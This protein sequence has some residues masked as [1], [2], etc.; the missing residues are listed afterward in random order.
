MP[1]LAVFYSSEMSAEISSFS[2]SASKPQH[3]I[4]NWLEQKQPIELT[5][6]NPVTIEQIC[7]AHDAAYVRDILA[8]RTN[9]GFHNRSA[10]VA[11]SLPYTSGSLLSAARHAI[12]HNSVAV[13]PSSGFH[14]A[15]HGFAEGYCTFNGLVIT[16]MAL[17]Q[18]DQLPRIGILDF[19]QHYGDG[20]DDIIDRLNLA[21][22]RHYTAG[23]DYSQPRQAKDFLK[24]IPQ[25]MEAFTD[26]AVLL[27]Q[28]GADPHIDDPL[29]GW[30][31]SEQ[32][33]QRDHLVFSSAKGLQLPIAWNLAGGY[34][35]PISKVLDI[36][37]ATLEE[38]CAV[39]GITA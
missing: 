5:V 2:P 13:S 8:L 7:A 4:R 19:D 1:K 9:N 31:T 38:C 15:H 17:H 10:D 27:Y 20:T 3:L 30:L 16:A 37:T 12:R 33:R 34:Q 14:H 21:F 25:L 32:L 22:V 6:P 26:C 29:G 35:N 39:Y 28:A 11:R 18:E 23:K 24:R 36:H